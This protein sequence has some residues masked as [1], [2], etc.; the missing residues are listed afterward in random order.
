MCA[1]LC[2]GRVKGAR[3][4]SRRKSEEEGFFRGGLRAGRGS[5]RPSWRR[6][7]TQVLDTTRDRSGGY[8]VDLSRGERNGRVSSEWFSRPADERYL[9]LSELFETAQI[10]SERSRMRT[11]ES[12]AIRVEASRDDAEHLT[13]VLPGSHVPI[14]PTHWSFGQPLRF[15][16]LRLCRPRQPS[17]SHRPRQGASRESTG[18]RA[19]RLDVSDSFAA[20]FL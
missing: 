20:S 14:E 13:L 15:P 18:D 7:M 5:R 8:K 6:P 9:S 11:V 17:R 3:P 2:L 10:R 16:R 19:G 4:F 1:L 12:A